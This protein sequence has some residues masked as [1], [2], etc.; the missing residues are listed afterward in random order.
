VLIFSLFQT[1]MI[2]SKEGPCVLNPSFSQLKFGLGTIEIL[3][4]SATTLGLYDNLLP[5]YITHLRKLNI[6]F[7]PLSLLHQLIVWLNGTTIITLVLFLTW[8]VVVTALP[9]DQG[10]G[11]ILRNYVGFFLSAFSSFISGSDDIII[12]ELSAIYHWLIIA[13]DLGVVEFVCYSDYLVCINL[14]NGCR[15]KYHVYTVLIQDMKEL[16][17]QVN[18]TICH[19]LREGN[20]CADFSQSFEFLRMLISSFTL[21]PQL[22]CSTFLKVTLME[23]SF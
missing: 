22:D 12:V 3:C 14:I 4:V 10:F 2:G 20:Q 6:A 16:L 21:L 15:E 17:H 1:R 19:T 9:S 11:G 7:E 18:V 8:M 23:P 5:T 13:K